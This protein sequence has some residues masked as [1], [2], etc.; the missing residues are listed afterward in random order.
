MPTFTSQQDIALNNDLKQFR[1]SF[2]MLN[3]AKLNDHGDKDL[4]LRLQTYLP[5]SVQSREL[6]AGLFYII[7]D[8]GCSI[9]ATPHKED[10]VYL[11]TL[12]KPIDLNGVGGM[13]QVTQAG[14]V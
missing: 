6:F 10:F 11:E 9:S 8:S 3:T 1:N 7:V 4:L 12:D 13:L 5:Y 14:V 2:G